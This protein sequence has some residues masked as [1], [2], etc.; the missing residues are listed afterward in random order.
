M[1]LLRHATTPAAA[2]AEPC[3][4]RMMETV[5]L[6][7]QFIRHQ[8]RSL[9]VHGLSVPQ[10]RTLYFINMHDEPSLSEAADWIGLSLPAMSRLV[11][12]LVKKALAT[13]T[14]CPDDRRCVRLGLSSAGRAAL[15]ASWSG[16]RTRLAAEMAALNPRERGAVSEAMDI[17]RVAFDPNKGVD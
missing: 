13:R 15:D 6:V 3:A 17:L 9:R 16:T 14:A 8:M 1:Q 12:G 2:G 10:L 4:K 11:D 5:P 7:M